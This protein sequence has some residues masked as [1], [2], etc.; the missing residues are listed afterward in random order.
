MRI[1]HSV[2]R[3]PLH[4]HTISSTIANLK[5]LAYRSDTT[6]GRMYVSITYVNV[7]VGDALLLVFDRL[8]SWLSS[9]LGRRPVRLQQ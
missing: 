6:W 5:N 2:Q 9:L 4:D 7:H 8:L 1:K 3:Q